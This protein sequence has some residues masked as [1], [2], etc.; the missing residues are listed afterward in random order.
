MDGSDLH[1][2]HQAYGSSYAPILYGHKAI[3]HVTEIGDTVQFLEVGDYV[4]IPDGIAN[5]NYTGE[6][7]RFQIPLVFCG[8]QLSGLQSKCNVPTHSFVS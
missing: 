5:G 1:M 8:S 6:P 3:G 7:D 2:H 4:V